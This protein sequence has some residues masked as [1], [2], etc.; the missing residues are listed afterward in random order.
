[1]PEQTVVRR[2]GWRR[3]GLLVRRGH[4]GISVGTLPTATL[5]LFMQPA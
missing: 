1:M 5:G 2:A 3:Y 4:D